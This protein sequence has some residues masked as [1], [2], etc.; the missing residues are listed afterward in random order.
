MKMLWYKAWLET[1][2]R[3]LL[4]IAVNLFVM[5]QI[6]SHAT[7]K[8]TA[9]GLLNSLEFMWA[10]IPLTLAGSGI[11]PEAPFRAMKGIQG[12]M[13]YTLSLP[14]SRLRLF[15]V[16]SGCGALE[17]LG[18]IV[19]TSCLAAAAIP[20]VRTQISLNDGLGYALTIFL[21]GAAGFGISTM[22]ATFLDQQWQ[23]FA[24][25][26]VVFSGRWLF[27]LVG[28]APLSFDFYRAMGNASPLV[29]HTLPFAAMGVSV[30]I[31]AVCLLA[32][33]TVE[34]IRQY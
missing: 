19:L 22:F 27:G 14:V 13:Y 6:Y 21:C 5:F 7:S 3:V 30:G 4:L 26:F 34:R 18:I 29:T 9:P 2:L 11:R 16:R 28:K 1:R 24:S 25:M 12:S 31:G 23:G 20:S 33:I 15:A 8:L 10:V 32:A 17:F